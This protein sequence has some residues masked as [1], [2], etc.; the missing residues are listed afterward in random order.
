ML[1]LPG[2]VEPMLAVS[3][4]MPADPARYGFEFKWDGV[5]ALVY[6][7]G[8]RL[9]MRSRNQIDI[10]ARYPELEPLGKS[11][12]RRQ[13][14][15]DGEIIALRGGRPSFAQLQRR[16]HVNNPAPELIQSVPASLV[17]FDVLHVDG[18]SVMDL[19][20]A[21]R[22]QLLQELAPAGPN[23]HLTPQQVGDGRAM[24]A[25]ARK[26]Q[27][28][29][30]VAKRLESVYEPGMRSRA[31][32][33][34]KLRLRQ[35]FVVGGWI[36]ESTGRPDRI[37]ALLIGYYD[38]AGDLQYAGRVGSGLA[39]RDHALLLGEFAP[40]QRPASPFAKSIDF[41]KGR[42][43]AA[44]R[45]TVHYLKPRPVVE[46]EY[47]RWPDGGLVQH[48]VYQGLRRDKSARSVVKECHGGR[49]ERKGIQ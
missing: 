30:L 37:G 29:G 40:L 5:R 49:T 2:R 36:G 7:S 26:N 28:E 44:P 22:R 35:E 41:R 10:T 42:F 23:W 21:R 39:C 4:A 24:L 33:K 25:T 9:L 32:I 11:L 20:Y 38:N 8:G 12:G 15:L 34:I 6:V 17:L 27:L 18:H 45:G 43:S 48:G 1:P 16:M 19:P 47:G 3:G 14:L 13:V 31:W 46:I